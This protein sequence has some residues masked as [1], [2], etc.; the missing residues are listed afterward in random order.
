MKTNELHRP[1]RIEQTDRH[2]RLELLINP[3]LHHP[4]LDSDG[5]AS[6]REKVVEIRHAFAR[7]P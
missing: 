1:S 4:R 2:R 7:L 6:H 3:L 5:R